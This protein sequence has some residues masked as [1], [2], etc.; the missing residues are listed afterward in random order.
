MFKF[1]KNCHV[2]VWV[3]VGHKYM[4]AILK[5]KSLTV[6][7]HLTLSI[8]SATWSETWWNQFYHRLIDINKSYLPRAAHQHYNRTT[9]QNDEVIWVLLYFRTGGFLNE[10]LNDKT[11]SCINFCLKRRIRAYGPARSYLR[12][13]MVKWVSVPLQQRTQPGKVSCLRIISGATM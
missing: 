5:H 9:E 13:N 2:T 6:S 12:R 10:L 4:W 1:Q 7:L 11:E 8:G 3:E